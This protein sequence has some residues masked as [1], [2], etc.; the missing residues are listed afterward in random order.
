MSQ[1]EFFMTFYSL[2]L[3]LGVAELMLG[4][5]NLLRRKVRPRLGLLT[6]LLGAAIFLEAMATFLD[7][8]I[9]LQDVALN[10]RGLAIPTLIGLCFF[11]LGTIAVPRDLEE[12]SSLDDYFRATRRWTMGLLLAVN[13]LIIAYEIPLVAN[14][15]ATGKTATVIRY[16]IVNGVLLAMVLTALL[17]RPRAII[18]AALAGLSLF[19]LYF[20]GDFAPA[21]F[22]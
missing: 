16:L 6:P 4:F 14:L 5:T 15:Y 8:W 17:A 21:M 11:V 2:L 13:L 22:G 3:G 9:K 18:A 1:F 7:A 19:F 20:Y 10:F 12:W